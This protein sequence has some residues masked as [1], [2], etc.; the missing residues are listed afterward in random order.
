VVATTQR[1]DLALGADEGFTAAKGL[2]DAAAASLLADPI[3]LAWVDSESR[4]ESPA[5]A[6]ECHGDCEI[7]GAVEYARNRG[8]ELEVVVDGGRYIFCYRSPGEFAGL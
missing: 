1:I 6:S 3:C 4:R 5:H 8:A 2:A 7:P